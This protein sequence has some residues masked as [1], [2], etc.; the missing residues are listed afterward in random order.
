MVSKLEIA[1]FLLRQKFLNI[2]CDEKHS[3]AALA[4]GYMPA[5]IVAI[6]RVGYAL[7][8]RPMAADAAAG[9][10]I[11]AAVATRAL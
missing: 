7:F 8:T 4:G 11:G 1:E 5:V 6:L 2:S 10:K 3:A 9:V